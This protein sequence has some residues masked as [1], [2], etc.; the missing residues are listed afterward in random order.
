LA[1]WGFILP[2]KSSKTKTPRIPEQA[3]GIQ[4]NFCKN[5]QCKNFGVTAKQKTSKSA[6]ESD[7]YVVG[8]SG[9]NPGIKCKACGE[10]PRLK[11]NLAIK[12]ECDRISQYLAPRQEPSCPDAACPNHAIGVLSNPQAYYPHGHSRAGSTRY[13]CKACDKT[14]A[15]GKSTRGQKMPEKNRQIFMEVVNGNPINRICELANVRPQTVYDK[16][17]FFQK[18][19]LKFLGDKERRLK[20]GFSIE[21]LYLS[22][23]RQDYIVN[24]TH[25]RDKRTT[26]LSAIGTADNGSG[27][28]FGMHLNFDSD[29]D[30]IATEAA[31]HAAGDYQV[32]P[33][34]RQ[35]ARLWL[36]QDYMS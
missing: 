2:K 3:G 31:A 17:D 21:K 25:R 33:P 19:C 1:S 30:P 13:K 15:V 24:W 6:P 35:F 8:S 14:F 11:S 5:P 29:A 20:G 28:V 26:Q 36:M 9:Q 4:V 34:F 23:D 12:Q 16:I 7:N 10:I 27:Y 32:K 18:Q 22:S